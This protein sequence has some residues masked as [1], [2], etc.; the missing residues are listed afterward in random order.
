MRQCGYH[1]LS[2]R[3]SHRGRT[4]HIDLQN[5]SLCSIS[6]RS[7]SLP[8]VVQDSILPVS[9]RAQSVRYG[10]GCLHSHRLHPMLSPHKRAAVNSVSKATK[11][12]SASS[13]L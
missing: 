4:A 9:E 6:L 1:V 11:S 13:H 10:S 7:A 12:V 8:Q 5:S 3:I 2:S